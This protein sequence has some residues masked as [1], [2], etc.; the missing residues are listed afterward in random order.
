MFCTQVIIL[1][2]CREV[3]PSCGEYLD[4]V[5]IPNDS[6]NTALLMAASTGGWA[7][8]GCYLTELTEQ[9]RLANGSTTLFDM[10]CNA[11]RQVRQ[12]TE[13]LDCPQLPHFYEKTTKNIV[14]EQWGKV[15]LECSSCYKP[16]YEISTE[17]IICET[18]TRRFHCAQPCSNVSEDESR[19]FRKP[20]WAWH[21]SMCRPPLADQ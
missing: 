15:N 3:K 8:A 20:G 16:T 11:A 19:L 6:N 7:W 17:I 5:D 1:N 9:F 14:L 10:H 18:C 12:D 4:Y 21:C 13:N 2:I